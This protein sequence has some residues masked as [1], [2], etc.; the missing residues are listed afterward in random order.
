MHCISWDSG[1]HKFCRRIFIADVIG[2]GTSIGIGI[3]SIGFFSVLV[4]PILFGQ[5][6]QYWH[7]YIYIEKKITDW[8][9]LKW[10]PIE[11]QNNARITLDYPK[12]CGNSRTDLS[13]AVS[14]LFW[15]QNNGT[16]PWNSNLSDY[17]HNLWDSPVLFLAL[18]RSSIGSLTVA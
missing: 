14:T 3:G 17:S 9:V 6:Y 12:D 11:D 18:F 7:L 16:L 10:L 4:L 13:S 5:Y 8:T 1:L 15:C 2:R